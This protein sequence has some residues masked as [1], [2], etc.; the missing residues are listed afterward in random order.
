MFC[1]VR[2]LLGDELSSDEDP[3]VVSHMTFP[4]DDGKVVELE[5]LGDANPNEVGSPA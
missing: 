3:T 2:P 5:K 4:D 1:R